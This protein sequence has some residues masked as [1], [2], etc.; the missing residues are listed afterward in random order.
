MTDTFTWRVHS[1]AAGGGEFTTAK[2][3]FGDGYSQEVALGINNEV[4]KWNVTVSER[5]SVLRDEA[6]DFIRDHRGLSF[7]WTPP[8][9]EEGYYRCKKYQASDQG[10]AYFTLNMEFEQV[11]EP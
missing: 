5:A 1:T 10:G 2:A 6:L 4:Q 3:Q 7:L 9:G 11:F 8:L